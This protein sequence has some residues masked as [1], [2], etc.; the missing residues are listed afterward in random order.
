MSESITI[1]LRKQPATEALQTFLGYLILQAVVLL[2]WWP[3]NSLFER[4]DATGE[5]STLAAVVVFTGTALAYFAIQLGVDEIAVSQ[6][7]VSVQQAEHG[8][9]LSRILRA[10]F[11][12]HFSQLG[13]LMA[14]CTPMT[15]VAHSIASVSATHLL[16]IAAITATHISFYRL[17]GSWLR[18]RWA[19]RD[20]L[21]VLIALRVAL[22]TICLCT[23]IYLPNLSHI[24]MSL[25]LAQPSDSA[26]KS[27]ATFVLPF[28]VTYAALSA[29]LCVGLARQFS[30][31]LS[32][33]LPQPLP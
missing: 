5:P 19:H 9:P 33:S 4:I 22:V 18:L 15:L 29:L 32:R 7:D 8:A 17:L 16:W 28:I 26:A 14:L 27:T 10:Y 12:V 6:A 3:V 1:E 25:Q 2:F 30:Q 21:L 31:R 11:K 24:S 23:I 20:V 13:Y